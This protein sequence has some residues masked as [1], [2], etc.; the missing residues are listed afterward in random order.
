MNVKKFDSK[1]LML[2]CY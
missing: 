2:C 1:L